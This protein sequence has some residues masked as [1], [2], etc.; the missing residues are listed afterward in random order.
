MTAGLSKRILPVICI[1][2]SSKSLMIS[3]LSPRKK[4]ANGKDGGKQMGWQGSK[5]IS[6]GK[7]VQLYCYNKI[8][9]VPEM[10]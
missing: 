2:S 9:V 6:F 10:F 7:V 3:C 1:K 4:T 5:N 8:T